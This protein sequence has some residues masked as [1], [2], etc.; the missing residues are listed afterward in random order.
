MD[1]YHPNRT[2]LAN[3]TARA[4][5]T[6]TMRSSLA[7]RNE[8]LEVHQGFGIEYCSLQAV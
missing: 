8:H 6:H 3:A 2:T 4:P 7:V 1:M 5:A